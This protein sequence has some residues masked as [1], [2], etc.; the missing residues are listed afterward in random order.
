VRFERAGGVRR[1]TR[2]GARAYGDYPFLDD[3]TLDIPRSV[4][5]LDTAGRRCRH[6][7]A[8]LRPYLTPHRPLWRPRQPELPAEAR[9]TV[10]S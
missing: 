7:G 9:V 3:L 1:R 10:H 2:I 6:V 4:F 5:R 8:I